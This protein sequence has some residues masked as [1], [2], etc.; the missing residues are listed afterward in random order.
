[1][2]SAIDEAEAHLDSG[3]MGWEVGL[4][5]ILCSCL[6][7]V[8]GMERGMGSSEMTGE[9][10]RLVGRL[11][12]SGWRRSVRRQGLVLDLPRHL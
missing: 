7:G 6:C 4:G 5:R 3:G 8:M 11:M 12:L 1:V 2:V 9:M 10:R